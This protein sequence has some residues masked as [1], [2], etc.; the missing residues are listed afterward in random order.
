M[1]AKD[2]RSVANQGEPPEAWFMESSV[3][4]WS[5]AL[6]PEDAALAWADENLALVAAWPANPLEEKMERGL[7]GT[8]ER[9]P[10]LQ[11]GKR[12]ASATYRHWLSS[13]TALYHLIGPGIQRLIKT[14]QGKPVLMGD[15]KPTQISLSHTGG[16]GAAAMEGPSGLQ[17]VG[18]DIEVL[19]RRHAKVL[20]RIG[21]EE[22]IQRVMEIAGPAMGAGLLWVIK[23]ACYKSGLIE[24]NMFGKNQLIT[25]IKKTEYPLKTSL[26]SDVLMNC[27]R[28][29]IAFKTCK[30]VWTGEVKQ[31]L[32]PEEFIAFE[33][34]WVGS[35]DQ[36]WLW[37]VAYPQ[38]LNGG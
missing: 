4:S 20:P 36:A 10:D 33:A 8:L 11:L 22:E 37:C 19:Q 32:S 14:S 28:T 25:K 18:V 24:G 23:E 16:M 12:R 15:Q 13:R 38:L 35:L 1:E 3:G 34:G 5:M 29:G 30:P 31:G 7:G 26:V 27:D 6:V 9:G 21:H 2:N 17:R